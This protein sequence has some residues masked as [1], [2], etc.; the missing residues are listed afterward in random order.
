MCWIYR[1]CLFS[2][3][4]VSLFGADDPQW[5]SK[6]ILQW[7]D[8]D[9]KQVL[10]DSPWIKCVK[11]NKVRDLSKFERRDGGNWEAGIGPTVD[12]AATGFFGPWLEDLALERARARAPRDYGSVVVRWESARPVQAAET[13]IG[14][15]GAPMWQ[16]DYYAIGVYGIQPPFH[17]NLANHLKGVAFLKRGGKRK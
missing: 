10:A 6:P 2:V 7:D 17:W 9:A 14:D 13:K 11:L 4:S 15:T 1:S 12:F 8:Q 3:V 5:K 16:G